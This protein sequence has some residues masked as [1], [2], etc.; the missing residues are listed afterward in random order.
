MKITNI[1]CFQVPPRWLFVKI[2]TDVGISGWGEP[3]IEGRAHTVAALI[4]ELKTVLLNKDPRKIQDIW[5][6]LYRGGFY[7]GGPIL[8]SGLAGID[9]A[10]WDIKGKDLNAPVYQLLGGACRDKIKAYSWVGGDEPSDLINAIKQIQAKG[11]DTVKLNAC[12]QLPM[13]A[14]KKQIDSIVSRIAQ[15]RETFGDSINFGIDFHGRVSLPNARVLVK[16]LETF[17]P[18][19]IEEPVLPEYAD[20]YASLAEMTSIP[21]AAGERF[22]SRFDFKPI[23]Q[24]GG[25]SI[26]QPDLSH[27]GGIS[28]CYKIATMAEA[29]DVGFAPH[30]P[31][32]PLALA[33]CLQVD[34][35]AFNT[36][37]QEHSLGIHY[38]N[39]YELTD[40]V[41]NKEMFTLTNGY[42]NLPTLPGLG[43]EI[44]EELVIER[45]KEITDWHNP[46]WR[47]KDNSIA[48]W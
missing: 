28:E 1:K 6:L 32:G 38:N 9:Q 17:R 16:E 27:A 30:C 39:E 3:V 10:L 20:M 44:N 40:Y 47:H 26:I 13:L 4:D 24:A 5:H 45:S 42:F 23:L 41:N 11:F 46:I 12:S 33:A 29:Y 34:A 2:E 18:L 22:Y 7:R 21:L 14:D 31:L 15:I 37:L 36:V 25:L 8:M 48:E 43:V 35:V 19:F